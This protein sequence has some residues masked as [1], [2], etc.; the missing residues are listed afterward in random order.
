[1]A[2]LIA[3]FAADPNTGVIAAYVED[4]RDGRAF[5]CAALASRTPVVLLAAGH[6]DAGRR[7]ALSHTGALVSDVAAVEAACRAAGVVRV[8]TP[9]GLVDAAPLLL[10]PR[11]PLGP[12]LALGRGGGGAGGRARAGAAARGR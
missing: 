10:S 12:R 11:R 6:S 9:R 2:D 8:S 3:T 1:V 4:F 5:A 7:G